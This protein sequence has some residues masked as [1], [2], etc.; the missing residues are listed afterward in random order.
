LPKLTKRIIEGITPD[1]HKHLKLWDTEIKGFGVLSS[2][3]G[4]ALIVLIIEIQIVS[5]R[6]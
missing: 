6:D 4:G 5:K 2:P 1:P 3:V